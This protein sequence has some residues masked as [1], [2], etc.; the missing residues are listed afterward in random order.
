MPT[1]PPQPPSLGGGLLMKVLIAV[2]F[3]VLVAMLALWQKLEP[4]WL[5]MFGAAL[6]ALLVWIGLLFGKRP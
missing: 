5:A 6:A 4:V 3:V 2:S 1:Q